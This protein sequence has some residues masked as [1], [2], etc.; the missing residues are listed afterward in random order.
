MLL[1][2]VIFFLFLGWLILY[3]GFTKKD[4]GLTAIAGFFIMALSIYILNIDYF[5]D[6]L[7]NIIW[8]T[9]FGSGMYIVI[10]AAIEIIESEFND[11]DSFNLIKAI[12]K[13][14]KQWRR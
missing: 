13:K 6:A 2:E 4:Y 11:G 14:I 1:L 10:R 9:H 8:T 7:R 12:R 3:I 5:D